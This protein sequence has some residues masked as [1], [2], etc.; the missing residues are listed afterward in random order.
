[1][2]WDVYGISMLDLLFFKNVDAM[3]VVCEWLAIH[4]DHSIMSDFSLFFL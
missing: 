3:F 4:R 1:M 2:I